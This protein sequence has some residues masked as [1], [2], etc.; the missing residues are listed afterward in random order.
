M[1]PYHTLVTFHLSFLS[2][3]L[4]L[5]FFILFCSILM[6]TSIFFFHCYVCSS[7]KSWCW[8]VSFFSLTKIMEELGVFLSSSE[9]L[10][11]H[12]Q[13][14]CIWIFH[15]SRGQNFLT[16]FQRLVIFA[17]YNFS[18]QRCNFSYRYWL[19]FQYFE[20]MK[21]MKM[22][23][24]QYVYPLEILLPLLLSLYFG[25]FTFDS[26]IH[27]LQFLSTF[28]PVVSEGGGNTARERQ[29]KYWSSR[30]HKWYLCMTD[31]FLFSRVYIDYE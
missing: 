21:C 29:K 20:S 13:F 9:H 16:S 8:L 31:T 18:G 4:F 11:T 1:S 26:A 7:L 23:H 12:F 30:L 6:V 14:G 19:D 27:C 17:E 2:L 5:W 22:C 3:Y 24:P 10:F 25:D 28:C 15:R